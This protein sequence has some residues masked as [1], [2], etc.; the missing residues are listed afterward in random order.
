MII[1]TLT[2][3]VGCSKKH[4]SVKNFTSSNSMCL[5]AL[6]INMSASGCEE[7]LNEAGEQFVRLE[8]TTTKRSAEGEWITHEFYIVPMTSD[9]EV[10]GTT[11]V[12]TD[13][14]LTISFAERD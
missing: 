12:C 7:Y 11:P 6:L 4:L 9:Y 3:A 14:N 8:C 2:V 10:P 5:D 13:R 1:A